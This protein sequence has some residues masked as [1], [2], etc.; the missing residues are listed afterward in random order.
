MDTLQAKANFTRICQ[1]LIDKGTDALRRALHVIHP[2][3]TLAAALHSHRKTLQ[4]LRYNV[5]NPPQWRLLYPAAGPPNSNDFDI[6]LLTILL[7]NIC[8][9]S[10]PITG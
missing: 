5:I 10:S 2:A 6:T 3:P 9:L 1:L 4:R 7:R 8:G